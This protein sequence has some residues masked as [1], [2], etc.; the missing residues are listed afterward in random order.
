MMSC[1]PSS[2]A[3]E[4]TCL[5]TAGWLTYRRS[6]ARE[7]EPSRATAA[8]ARSRASISMNRSY[9]AREKQ[10]FEVLILSAY[11]GRGARA[12][13]MPSRAA[14]AAT[15]EEV[16]MRRLAMLAVLIGA[17]ATLGAVA[18]AS[19]AR[20][21]IP[22]SGTVWAVERFDGGPNTLA[23]FDASTGDVLS[24]VPVGRRP[25]GV[26][27]PHGTGKVYTAD[28]RSNQMTVISKD[29]L[30]V[31]KHIPIGPLPHPIM[32]RPTGKFA[33]VGDN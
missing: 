25:I 6:A 19:N 8:K 23:A 4:A 1:V 3:S 11:G 24:V 29:D 14:G 20:K 21:Q 10:V 22:V 31:L 9:N 33:Y 26:T 27:A 12:I 5:D 30:S 28:E 13:P 18:G 15:A 2:A 32:A 17:L 7:N 16:P